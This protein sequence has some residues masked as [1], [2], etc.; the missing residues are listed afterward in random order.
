MGE[1]RSAEEVEEVTDPPGRGG[2]SPMS[3]EWPAEGYDSTEGL[4]GG[5]QR[6]ISLQL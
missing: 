2:K 6:S 1:Q 4:S 3:G 5:Q